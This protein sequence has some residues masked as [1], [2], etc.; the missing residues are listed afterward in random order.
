VSFTTNRFGTD[1]HALS[2]ARSHCANGVFAK[3]A[4]SWRA[5]PITSC[6]IPIEFW[7]G[8]LQSLCSHCHESR[9]KRFE[10]RGY[11]NTI[12]EDGWPI[13]PRHP[14]YRNS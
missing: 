14:V 10:H 7:R 5:S 4:S 9:K 11:D 12:G 6:R 3:A 8:K 13:D 2:C 1:A